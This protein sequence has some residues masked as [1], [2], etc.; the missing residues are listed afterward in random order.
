MA[1]STYVLHVFVAGERG[2][3]RLGVQN[4]KKICDKELP[5]RYKIKV[6]DVSQNRRAAVENNL[7]ALPAV[8]RTL[9][10]PVR[11]FV[12]NWANEKQELVGFGLVT[13]DMPKVKQLS[14]PRKKK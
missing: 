13:Q 12:G 7:T 1:K 9:P 2:P 10:S 8:V 4:L 14:P 5:G 6:I 11:K 3:S